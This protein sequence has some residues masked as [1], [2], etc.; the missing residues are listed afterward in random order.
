MT[1]SSIFKA[2]NIAPFSATIFTSALYDFLPPSSKDSC[3]CIGPT[4]IIQDNFPIKS[5]ISIYLENFVCHIKFTDS[6]VKDIDFFVGHYSAY[7][8]GGKIEAVL[9]RM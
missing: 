4:G 1:P 9:H 6:R 2:I 3:D 7:H 8:R 5:L